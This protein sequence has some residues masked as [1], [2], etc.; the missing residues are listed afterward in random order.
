MSFLVFFFTSFCVFSAIP[1]PPPKG[2]FTTGG[3]SSS[4]PHYVGEAAGGKTEDAQPEW[5]VS[6]KRIV[7]KGKE[8]KEKKE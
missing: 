3:M 8:I 6:K 5:E 7:V 4:P 2:P 1:L